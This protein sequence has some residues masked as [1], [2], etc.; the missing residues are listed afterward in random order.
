MDVFHVRRDPGLHFGMLQLFQY[1]D[2]IVPSTDIDLTSN[3]LLSITIH[4]PLCQDQLGCPWW[5]VSEVIALASVAAEYKRRATRA[6]KTMWGNARPGASASIQM[7]K[8]QLY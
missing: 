2:G 6:M 5:A 7:G 4:P 3:G 8:R 1:I